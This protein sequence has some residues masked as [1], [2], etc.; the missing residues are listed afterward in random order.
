MWKIDQPRCSTPPKSDPATP[1]A[2]HRPSSMKMISPAYM[3]PYSRSE[4][5]RGFDTY[6]TALKSRLNGHSSGLAPNGEQKS[7]CIHPPRPLTLMLY[8][9]VR[10]NT[11]SDSANVVLTSA[12]GTPRQLC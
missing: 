11:D 1:V 12:V 5:E 6:S 10:A 2:A 3:F 8:L 9:N 7:S 4:C